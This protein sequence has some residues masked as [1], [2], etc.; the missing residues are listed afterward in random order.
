MQLQAKV[1]IT[2]TRD[3]TAMNSAL[4][5]KRTTDY[6]RVAEA[7]I[8]I[9]AIAICCLKQGESPAFCSR[10]QELEVNDCKCFRWPDK[11]HIMQT[12]GWEYGS[13]LH[14]HNSSGWQ[15]QRYSMSYLSWECLGPFIMWS[16]S[17]PVN[18][19]K[20]HFQLSHPCDGI[21]LFQWRWIIPVG[22]SPTPEVS[23]SMWIISSV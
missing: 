16:N 21:G 3:Q 15:R 20:N 10:T 6:K 13:I 14:H 12:V 7:K 18:V 11:S 19:F 9:Y 2:W 4:H 8:L 23:R 1:W 22:Q 17:W 5:I